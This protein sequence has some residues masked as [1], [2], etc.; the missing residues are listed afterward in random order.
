MDWP[1]IL[2]GTKSYHTV[3][4]EARLVSEKLQE[5]GVQVMSP[6]PDFTFDDRISPELSVV[7]SKGEILALTRNERRCRLRVFNRSSESRT[8]CE[9]PRMEHALECDIAAMDIDVEDN[10]YLITE[11][12]IDCKLFIFDENGNKKFESSLPF[13]PRFFCK[14]YMALNKDGKIAILHYEK[15]NIYIGKACQGQNLFEVEKN[16][17][18]IQLGM[19]NLFCLKMMFADFNSTKIVTADWLNIYIYN[20]DNG[21]MERKISTLELGRIESVTINQ[22]MRRVVVTVKNLSTSD[23]NL[24]SFS[25]TGELIDSLNL[26]SSKWIKHAALI[27]HPN[28]PVALVDKTGATLLQR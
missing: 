21:K 4:G 10:I 19:E 17:F 5:L 15:K 13:L 9:I 25:E 23:Y 2:F 12:H 14:K 11:F 8:L 16:L 22:V 24:L 27:S 6:I 3:F 20:T 28:G 7:N 18:L 26:G 1:I